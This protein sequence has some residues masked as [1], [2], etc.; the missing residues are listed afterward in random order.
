MVYKDRFIGP[1]QINEAIQMVEELAHEQNFTAALAGGVAMQVYGS[2]RMTN[3]VDFV[4][5]E[6]PTSVGGLR[7]VLPLGFGGTRYVTPKGAKVD[8]IV[9]NDEYAKLFEDAIANVIATPEGIPIVSPEHL[10][11]M[12]LA[13]GR[14]K[15]KL[16]LEWL[17][18]AEGLVD[19]RKARGIIYRFMGRFAQDRFDDIVEEVEIKKARNARRGQ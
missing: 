2:D 19:V 10:T 9:R 8:L 7:K 3:D 13:A 15:D 16:D 18:S 6:M 5:D 12:K 14:D 4:L 17:L 11:A 1:D